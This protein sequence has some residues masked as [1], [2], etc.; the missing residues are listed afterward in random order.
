M[1]GSRKHLFI[2]TG[3]V[4]RR[5]NWSAL[6]AWLKFCFLAAWEDRG[7]VTA[8]PALHYSRVCV[9][10]VTQTEPGAELRLPRGSGSVVKPSCR[11]QWCGW[12]GERP[13]NP[14]APNVLCD[15]CRGHEAPQREQHC[16]APAWPQ[17]GADGFQHSCLH[18]S[19]LPK[20]F[21]LSVADSHFSLPAVQS[22]KY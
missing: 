20:C 17:V 13:Q 7:R 14:L 22:I 5:G 1:S 10:K 15:G 19:R 9:F 8:V 18:T 3:N 4:L 2:H 6:C 12:F 16:K 11:G 21:G